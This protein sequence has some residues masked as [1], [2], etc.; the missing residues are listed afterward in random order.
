M[1][2]ASWRTRTGGSVIQIES[3]AGPENWGSDVGG[4]GGAAGVTYCWSLL[5]TSLGFQGLLRP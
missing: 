1:S 3:E 5:I 4:N 2:S